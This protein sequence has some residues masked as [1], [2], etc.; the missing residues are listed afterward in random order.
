MVGLLITG[1]G[2]FATG[3]ASSLKLVTGVTEHIACVDFEEDHS[4]EVLTEHLNDAL[5]QLGDCAGVLVLADLQGG[6]PFKCAVECKYARPEAKIEVVAGVNLPMLVDGAMMMGEYDDPVA[7]SDSLIET[8][9]E[10]IVR[11]ELQKRQED[12]AEE[13]GI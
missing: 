13:D 1:H 3:L 4:T 7:F 11:F 2:H 12:E 8:G 6:S 10:Y 9:R 5:K